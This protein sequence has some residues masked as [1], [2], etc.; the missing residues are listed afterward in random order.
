[1][2][3]NAIEEYLQSEKKKLSLEELKSLDLEVL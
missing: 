1:M 3:M 2:N